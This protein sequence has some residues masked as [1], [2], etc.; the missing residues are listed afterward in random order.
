MKKI[1]HI[2][3]IKL[4]YYDYLNKRKKTSRKNLLSIIIKVN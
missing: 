1:K 3:A 4:I 2:K